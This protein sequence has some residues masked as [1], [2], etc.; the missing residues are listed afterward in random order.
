MSWIIWVGLIIIILKKGSDGLKKMIEEHQEQERRE[1][2]EAVEHTAER[3]AQL[4]AWREEARS[5]RVKGDRPLSSRP[6]TT[7]KG[8]QRLDVPTEIEGGRLMV[9]VLEDNSTSSG[10]AFT[11]EII[12]LDGNIQHKLRTAIVMKE[13][14][15]RKV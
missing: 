7:P 11:E 6:S 1:I 2:E 12:H 13:I 9:E 3:D 5:K 15:D 14:L 8:Y 10:N 4:E